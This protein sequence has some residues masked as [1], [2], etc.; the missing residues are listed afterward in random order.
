MLQSYTFRVV[1]SNRKLYLPRWYF[2]RERPKGENSL[3][4]L[5][6]FEKTNKIERKLLIFM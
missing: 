3:K 5:I 1:Y 6:Q 2:G 4:I